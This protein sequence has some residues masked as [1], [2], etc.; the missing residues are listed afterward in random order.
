MSGPSIAADLGSLPAEAHQPQMFEFPKR[1]FGEKVYIYISI[2]MYS[3]IISIVQFIQTA[4]NL[5]C[6]WMLSYIGCKWLWNH[7][8]SA[9]NSKFSWGGMPPDPLSRCV[10][11]MHI[12]YWYFH[13]C[14]QWPLHFL[15]A[16]YTTVVQVQF[17]GRVSAL[18]CRYKKKLLDLLMSLKVN[19]K[20]EVES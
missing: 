19:F 11:C 3:L 18:R 13:I 6:Q 8:R 5:S 10:L 14:Y 7:L 4:K 17:G 16:S 20:K 15:I 2:I 12:L 9:K 1:S